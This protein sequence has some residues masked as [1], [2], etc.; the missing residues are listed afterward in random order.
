VKAGNLGDAA[1]FSF[2][3]GKN[4]G[5]LGDGGA[6]TTNDSVLADVIRAL[7][8]YG[9]QKKYFN[10]YKGANSRLDE[11]QAALLR[12]KLKYLDGENAKRGEIANIYGNSIKN[13]SVILPKTASYGAHVWHLYVVRAVERERFQKYLEK[14][15]IQ[16][17]IHYPVAPHNQQAYDELSS[18]SLPVTEQIHREVIS[19]PMSPIL[20]KDEAHFVVNVINRFS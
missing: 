15:G 6:V 11:I 1:G 8:N 2:Y 5:A 12:I 10:L 18:L 3:P 17:M 9:S 20:T 13:T 14:N 4:L 7:R 19:L 16:T